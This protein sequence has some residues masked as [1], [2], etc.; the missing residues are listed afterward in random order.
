M[1]AKSIA[2]TPTTLVDIGGR[3]LAATFIGEGEP[4]VLLEVGLGAE[5]QS[6]AAVAEGVAGFT[7]VC[8]YDRAGRGSSDP[9]P[10]PRVADDLVRDVYALVHSAH[11]STP[12]VFV[13]QSF[14]GL[15]ARLYAYHHPADVAGIVLVDSFHEDQFDAMAPHFPAA[16]S[17]EPARLS[18]MR[19]FWSGGWRDPSQNYEGIDMV[20]CLAS[21]KRT[22]SLGDIPIRV[23]TAHSF[24]CQLAPHFPLEDG[25]R[26]QEIWEE[27]QSRFLRLSTD[28]SQ[29][30][31]EESGHFIQ[32]DK[33][34][35]VVDAIARLVEHCRLV[36]L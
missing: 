2:R 27:L 15:I 35:V 23:L 31:I 34:K 8:Y 21:A 29:R 3:R 4:L 7:R 13:G 36:R 28:A 33:P 6:W 9:A 19:A 22:K 18:S 16:I 1:S 5:S 14:G 10:Q 11:G 20:S 32:H 12:C 17:D 30:I 26:L 24:T 25:Q